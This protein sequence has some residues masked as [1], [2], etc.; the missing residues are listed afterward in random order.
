MKIKTI[1]IMKTAS[2]KVSKVAVFCLIIGIFSIFGGI[3]APKYVFSAVWQNPTVTPPNFPS[4]LEPP[5]NTSTSTQTK[6]GGLYV[7]TQDGAL[8]VGSSSTAGSNKLYVEGT[9]LLNGNVNVIGNESV[10]GAITMSDLLVSGIATITDDLNVRSGLLRVDSVT[11]TVFINSTN[12]LGKLSI[13]T[14]DRSGIYSENNSA[15]MAAVQATNISTVGGT[16]IYGYADQFGVWGVSLNG[17]GVLA[18]ASLTGIGGL[19]ARGGNE[20][21]GAVGRGL[22]GVVGLDNTEDVYNP[23]INGPDGTLAALFQGSVEI[24]P[25]SGGNADFT[26]DTNT[27]VVNSSTDGVGIGTTN[28]SVKLHV[29]GTDNQSAIYAQ[30]GINSLLPDYSDPTHTVAG[31]YGEGGTVTYSV[32]GVGW[33]FGVYGKAGN[34]G[35]GKTAGILGMDFNGAV[36]SYAGFFDGDVKIDGQLSV[37]GPVEIGD[38]LDVDGNIYGYGDLNLAGTG[39]DIIMTSADSDITLTGD[40]SAG[41]DITYNGK[42]I[43]TGGL[44]AM[45]GGVA[46]ECNVAPT[47]YAE[48]TMFVC[49]WCPS[50]TTQ[51]IH[52]VMARLNGKWI[53]IGYSKGALCGG[54]PYNPELPNMQP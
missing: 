44:P 48:G 40:I 22:Y 13:T 30:A 31:V 3:L 19:Y 2:L 21:Y 42:L 17:Y 11:D 25:S 43:M 29:L 9:T 39:S 54:D 49:Y 20:K 35:T 7:A 32:A 16:G 4:E 6:K 34:P 18:D 26:V 23:V 14:G 1:K 38:I 46:A 15:T 12:D 47:Y 24:V 52:A 27:F 50:L 8:V 33:N 36:N 51:R 10:S 53:N 28:P 5:I 37:V 41:G 45:E